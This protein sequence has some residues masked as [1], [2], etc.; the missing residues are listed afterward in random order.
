[1]CSGSSW[2]LLGFRTLIS[3]TWVPKKT[4]KHFSPWYP[5]LWNASLNL[6]GGF[7]DSK[8]EKEKHKH[9][10]CCFWAFRLSKKIDMC[11][12]VCVCLGG[13][14]NVFFPVQKEYFHS[15]D[16]WSS[17]TGLT[18]TFPSLFH[19]ALHSTVGTCWNCVGNSGGDVRWLSSNVGLWSCLESSL[20]SEATNSLRKDEETTWPA[21]HS[22][23]WK[24]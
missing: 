15:Q 21:R 24:I 4:L 14:I 7:P 19:G 9:D 1:M 13:V 8:G 10:G 6:T 3:Q 22:R 16:N 23:L 18:P 17:V 2:D 5:N 20:W 12:C 11:V